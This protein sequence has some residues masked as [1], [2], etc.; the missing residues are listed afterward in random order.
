MLNMIWGSFTFNHQRSMIFSHKL[1]ILSTRDFILNIV[2]NLSQTPRTS[3]TIELI[4]LKLLLILTTVIWSHWRWIWATVY[5]SLNIWPWL[6]DRSCWAAGDRQC[7]WILFF[8]LVKITKPLFFL[9]LINC[10]TYLKWNKP[11]QWW[12]SLVSGQREVWL[13]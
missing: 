5:D 6:R 13:L 12:Y 3:L 1:M 9:L 8:F 2:N 4:I 7:C 11:L 10:K